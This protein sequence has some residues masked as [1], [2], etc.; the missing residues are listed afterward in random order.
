MVYKKEGGIAVAY[1][2]K[3]FFLK[4]PITHHLEIISL[5]YAFYLKVKYY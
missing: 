4:K 5:Y 2:K 1:N 3:N